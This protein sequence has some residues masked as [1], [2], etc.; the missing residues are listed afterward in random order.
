MITEWKKPLAWE[1]PYDVSQ[2]RNGEAWQI[3][4]FLRPSWPS[5]PD[6]R[7][8]ELILPHGNIRRAFVDD[9]NTP[10]TVWIGENLGDFRSKARTARLEPHEADSATSTARNFRTCG[11]LLGVT[12]PTTGPHLSGADGIEIFDD[13]LRLLAVGD[14]LRVMQ[15]LLH[16]LLQVGKPCRRDAWRRNQD[17]AELFDI[18]EEIHNPGPVRIRAGACVDEFKGAGGAGMTTSASQTA[19]AT[20]SAGARRPLYHF[21]GHSG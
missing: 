2:T 12:L 14:E 4:T 3:N 11:F 6:R 13:P 16:R 20:F 21:N 9:R 19:L 17:A 15:R 5:I 8:N 18:G 1:A 10:V 7:M